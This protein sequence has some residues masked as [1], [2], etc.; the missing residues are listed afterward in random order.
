MC[1]TNSYPLFPH[2]Y[3][4]TLTL[5]SLTSLAYSLIYISQAHG[6]IR[7][8]ASKQDWSKAYNLNPYICYVP[9]IMFICHH[10][11]P[12]LPLRPPLLPYHP[13]FTIIIILVSPCIHIP[14]IS[15]SST[16]HSLAEGRGIN[17][18]DRHNSYL[19]SPLPTP[20]LFGLSGPPPPPPLLSLFSLF[21]L[22]ELP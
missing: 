18:S 4:L 5:S 22:L 10:A 7:R 2:S 1:T 19:L 3:T 15:V 20:P 8:L 11:L 12:A 21:L 6:V 17:S 9:I 13:T 14:C 16:Q